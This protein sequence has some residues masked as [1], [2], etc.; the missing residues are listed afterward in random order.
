M[1]QE[2]LVIDCKKLTKYYRKKQYNGDLLVDIV[3]EFPFGKVKVN[4]FLDDRFFPYYW[5]NYVGTTIVDKK[6]IV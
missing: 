5:V 6:D 4:L 2:R 1:K 3:E